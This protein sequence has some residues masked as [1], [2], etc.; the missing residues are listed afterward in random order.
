MVFQLIGMWQILAG[1]ICGGILAE[2]FRWYGL[3]DSTDLAVFS[4]SLYYWG[5]T[6]GM[7]IIGG[8][9]TIITAG[10]E[11]V[12]ALTAL[13]LGAS[14][15]AM[16]AAALFAGTTPAQPGSKSSSGQ[17]LKFLAGRS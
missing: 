1:G 4:K 2:F 9:W 14:A 5:L 17:T 11:S 8:V 13:S 6:V 3:K 15:P 7:I 12:E 16:I 10:T